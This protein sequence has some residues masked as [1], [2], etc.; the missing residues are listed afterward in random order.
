VTGWVETQERPGLASRVRV[1]N[2][3]VTVA[4]FV[5]PESDLYKQIERAPGAT[6][7]YRRVDVGEVRVPQIVRVE[8]VWS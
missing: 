1:W 4:F 5:D 2:G 8:E 7:V 6:F 3:E